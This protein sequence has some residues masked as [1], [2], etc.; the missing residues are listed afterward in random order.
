MNTE[1]TRKITIGMPGF[2]ARTASTILLEKLKARYADGLTCVIVDDGSVR[3]P[4]VPDVLSSR[5]IKGS[6]IY[7]KRN[8]GHQ[9]AIAIGLCYAEEHESDSD[10]IVVM[11]SDG[12]DDPETIDILLTALEGD[13]LDVAVAERKSRV[14]TL[15]FK[16]F[17]EIYR[18]VFILLTGR[19]ISF[20]NFMAMTPAGLRR[21]AAMQEIYTHIAGSVITSRLR[22]TACPIARGP[23]LAG[24]SRMNFVSLALHG[25]RA[26]MLF[27]EDVLVRVGVACAL[28]AVLS[29]IAGVIAVGLKLFGYATPGWFSV[30]IGILMLV[31]LQTGAVTLMT[32]LLTGVVKGGN[33]N[34]VRYLDFVQRVERSGEPHT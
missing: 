17:Y 22:V 11:D 24:Q 18:Q 26:V 4:V 10:Y 3:E 21:L 27:A 20:G 34:R 16:I 7:L 28:V 15:R 1:T 13:E 31:F 32:L 9:S 8:V 29:V 23:R 6:V 19:R 2:E 30:A 12:E 14:E 25:F 5:E 33:A